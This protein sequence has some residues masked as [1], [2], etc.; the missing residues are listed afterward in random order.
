[1]L[2]SALGFALT[3]V[4]TAQDSPAAGDAAPA[5][6][7]YQAL[8]PT[9][10]EI[11]AGP[12]VRP[13]EP[14]WDAPAAQGDAPLPG[15]RTLETPAAV[16]AYVG[17]YEVTPTDAE[18]VYQQGVAAAAVRANTLMGPLDGRWRVFGPDGA[19]VL[20]LLLADRGNGGLVEGAWRDLAAP[21]AAL[22]GRRLGA[23]GLVTRSGD[24]LTIDVDEHGGA[25]LRLDRD[26]GRWRGTLE[27]DGRTLPV[28]MTP[29]G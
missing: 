10:H 9:A 24:T 4:M 11:Y 21:D 27:R 7:P 14:S 29:H 16:D 6:V 3:I 13:Y 20:E 1:M 18:V 26:G 15:R 19:A 22:A 23:L 17:A 5:P 28:T 12:P 25:R 8:S 2:W